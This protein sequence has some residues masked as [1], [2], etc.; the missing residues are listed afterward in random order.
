MK[1]HK[2]FLDAREKMKTAHRVRNTFIFMT[3]IVAMVGVGV[4]TSNLFA[5][6][7]VA[8]AVL[9]VGILATKL[10]NG[11]TLQ[12]GNLSLNERVELAIREARLKGN[13]QYLNEMLD[14]KYNSYVVLGMSKFSLDNFDFSQLPKWTNLPSAITYFKKNNFQESDLMNPHKMYEYMVSVAP[15]MFAK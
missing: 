15:T 13:Y 4:V 2:D 12:M 14:S 6:M 11:K 5:I 3:T 7:G 9:C 10:N 8:S 1:Q